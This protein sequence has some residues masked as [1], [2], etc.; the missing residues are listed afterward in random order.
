MPEWFVQAKASVVDENLPSGHTAQEVS[1]SIEPG[2]RPKPGRHG[3]LEWF[4]HDPVPL[5]AE[6]VFEEHGVQAASSA[7]A[8]P[9][10]NP[11]PRGQDVIE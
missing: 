6:N 7:V 9:G 2:E 3:V 8:E 10:L 11:C 5:V 1:V 4:M